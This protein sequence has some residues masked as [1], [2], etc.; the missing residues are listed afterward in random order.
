M[1]AL[2]YAIFA[3]AVLQ[4]A[5]AHGTVTGIMADG[6]YYQGYS[7]SMQFQNPPPK[8]VGWSIPQD[9]SNGFVAPDKY[10]DPDII[11]HVGAKPAPVAAN[12]TAG[13][14]VTVFWTPWPVS[15]RGPVMD[16]LAPCNGDCANVN[17]ENLQ[18]FKVDAVGLVDGSKA[19]GKWAS[20]DMIAK[21]NSWTLTIPSNLA[22]GRY[23]LRHE[24]IALHD[25]GRDGGAQNYPQCINL[26]VHGGGSEKP[27]GVKATQLYKASDAGIKINI[28][29]DNIQYSIPGPALISGK[30]QQTHER[31]RKIVAVVY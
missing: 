18:F 25:A 4:A 5:N 26:D 15:H 29:K 16:Y 14:S 19:P 30:Q 9:L 21:N 2:K 20:D 28:Y 11:C 22:A 13:S 1:A 24:T 12:V 23:V 17:K 8:V 7:P 27:S 3:L 6:V 31:R 10:S